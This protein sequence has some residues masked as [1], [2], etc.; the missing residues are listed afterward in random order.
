MT[1]AR[2]EMR[3]DVEIKALAEKAAAIQGSKS[4]TDYITQL[5]VKD[6]ADVVERYE[7]IT[8]KNSVFDNFVAACEKTHRPNKK[9]KAAAKL[10][11]DMGLR[12]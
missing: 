8:L 4:L 2:L 9:L 11:K 6:A 10:H 1:I 5:I 3:I 12:K 7:S